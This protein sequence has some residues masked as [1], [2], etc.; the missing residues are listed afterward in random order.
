M[1][2]IVTEQSVK[3]PVPMAI[4]QSQ[5]IQLIVIN[6]T[7]N[8]LEKRNKELFRR[9]VDAIKYNEQSL[10]YILASELTYIRRL[11]LKLQNIALSYQSHQLSTSQK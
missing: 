10:S 2:Q 1:Y 8:I 3:T 5:F 11:K 7:I 9:L 4:C 6:N